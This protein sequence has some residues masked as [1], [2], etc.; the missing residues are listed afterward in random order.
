MKQ[1]DVECPLCGRM[2][3]GLFLEETN[4][5]MECEAC[6]NVTINLGYLCETSRRIPVYT[7]EQFVRMSRRWNNRTTEAGGADV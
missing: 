2:N 5:E 4:G 3:R 7:P 1:Y 6:G